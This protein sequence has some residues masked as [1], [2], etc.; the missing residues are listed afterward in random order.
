MTPIDD[1]INTIGSIKH[2]FNGI[3]ISGIITVMIMCS[4]PMSF[5]AM[6]ARSLYDQGMEA[7]KTGN[8]G[9]AELLFRKIIE[10]GD[11]EYIDRAWFHLAR[12][13]FS[14]GK[15]EL[16]LFE[17]KNFLN[18][19]KTN[20]LSAESRYWMGESYYNISDYANAIEE[21]RRYIAVMS[22]NDLAQNAHDRI[23]I[24]Y[25][26]QKRY[27]EAII[28]WETARSKSADQHKNHLRQY[29]IGDAL[30][31]NGKYDEALQKLAPVATVNIDPRV[32]AMTDMVLGRIYQKKGDHQKSLQ[33][34]SMIPAA[35][36]KELPFIEVQYF[37]ARSHIRLGQKNQ[38]RALIEAFLANGTESRW[39]SNA[40]YELGGILIEGPEHEDGLKILEEVR[41]SSAR[42]SLKSRAS[43]KL[44][45]YYAD[46]SPD[47]SIPYLD[48]ALKS[49][50]QDKRK[51]LLEFTGKT[52]MRAKKFDKAIN[53]F[54]L[55]IKENP[56]DKALDEINFLRA[57]AYLEMGQIDRAT[58][59]FATNRKENPFSKYISE[60]N[61]YMAL[62]RYK[63]GNTS[64][65]IT[66]LREYLTQKNGE[67]VYEAH[68]LLVRI[69]LDKDDIDNA[70][71]AVDAL[72]REFMNRKDVETVL[73]D[74]ATALLKKGRDARRFVNLI[75]NRF[76]GS[77]SAAEIYMVLGNDSFNRNRYNA[78][79]ECFNNYLHSPYTKNRGNAFYKM[80]VS[81]YRMKRYDDVIAVIKK[82][83]FPSMTEYQWKE[84]P[85]IQARSYYALEKY[86][87]VYMS[88][89]VKN[90]RDYPKDDILMYIRCA[91]RSGD[92]RSAIEANELLEGNKNVF[93]ES[94]YI[95]GDYLL[96]NDH[97][98][99]AELYFTK[100]INEYQG[101]PHVDHARLSIGEMNIIEKKYTEAINYLSSVNAAAD[102]SIHNRKNSLLI[103]CYL[104]MGKVDDAI[105]LTEMNLKNLLDSE[106]GEQVFLSMVRH[107]YKKRELQK[108]E[109]YSK[110][111]ARYRGNE[112]EINYLSGK[113]YFQ[114]GNYHN[115]YNYFLSLS[116]IKSPH[117]DEA[118]YFIG[119]YNLLVL[120]NA[121]NALTLFT[122]ISDIQDADESVIR[123]GL[124]QC[125]IIYHEMN[126]DE[127]ARE[128]LNRVIAVQHRG[129]THIQALN[130]YNEFNYRVK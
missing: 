63:E 121:G 100:I 97:R 64:K 127:K 38:A 75:L 111:L 11:D 102:K 47:R 2:F 110:F 92:Y 52:C 105:S 12:S 118:Y 94:L 36:L 99:E 81:M 116:R 108:F 33:M 88:L 45:Q 19:C 107:Y 60:S 71:R 6:D 74:Y 91:L 65:A 51:S 44:G 58:N 76:P 115:A 48:D 62:V 9:S 114:N 66:L 119:L 57:R 126:N 109:R 54:N 103:R 50:R 31:R 43:L 67:Q 24:I 49:S 125:A 56:F 70:G 7:F 104:E 85:L 41:T 18:R 8:Y 77:E 59:I 35:Y 79:L 17:F 28:E 87:D 40:Q 123:K 129:M 84:I 80:L 96:R 68:I 14:K 26:S 53:Y 93:S 124:I 83:N 113:I 117:Q 106:Y 98:D 13:I 61:Y 55:Y 25:L 27:D 16:A 37:K 1:M 90:L 10:S 29:W 22:D 95:I 5:A 82:G 15:Y 39:Y 128:C 34:F 46:R 89:D 86:E 3:G 23:G 20:T 73:Y 78:A 32:N 72:T 101:T 120:K 21:F 130:L 69:Y 122:R 42:P 112:P 4:T 30:Y